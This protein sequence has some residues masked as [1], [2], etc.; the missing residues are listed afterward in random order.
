MNKKILQILGNKYRF[1]RKNTSFI[2]K[3]IANFMQANYRNFCINKI[4]FHIIVFY[5]L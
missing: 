3:L 5:L 4:Y 2:R 1:F